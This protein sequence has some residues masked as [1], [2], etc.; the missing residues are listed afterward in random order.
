MRTERV[1]ISPEIMQDWA[2]LAVRIR[3][4]GNAI[5]A[6]TI[7][8][9]GSSFELVDGQY[10]SEAGSQ[11]CREGLRS[12]VEHLNAWADYA[13]PLQH[14]DV[15]VVN[16]EGF[17]WT[18]TLVR[19]A[20]EGAAQS[21][22]LS[23]ARDVDQCVGRLIRMVRH[24]LTEQKHAWALLGRDTTST[25]ER[26]N[27]HAAAA[28]DYAVHEKPV[29]KLPAMVDMVR[30]AAVNVRL[31]ADQLAADWR[32]CSAAAH[33]KEWAV[34]ELQVFSGSTEW[35]PGQFHLSGHMDPHRFTQIM[36]DSVALLDAGV[37]RYLERS[38]ADV[39]KVRVQGLIDAAA[40]TP[41][42]DDGV[43]RAR[44][45]ER[46]KSELSL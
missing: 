14:L 19:A 29:D 5:A 2:A 8:L 43:L 36:E 9:P 6:V 4:A 40:A 10:L 38:G 18:F 1:A 15:R 42:R 30:L 25:M 3:T 44:T 32:V 7:P 20:L 45:T 24:D 39:V 21:L 34:R 13:V 16:H 41:Q 22:W 33:G 31:G 23:G 17:R 12:A 26:V 27:R 37:I 35:R 28:A 46:L 11:W